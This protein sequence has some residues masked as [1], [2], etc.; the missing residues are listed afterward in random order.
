MYALDVEVKLGEI[1][2][3][4]PKGGKH[5]K[6]LNNE[7]SVTKSQQIGQARARISETEQ[8]SKHPHIVAQRNG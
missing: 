1:Y 6:S 7:R 4:V 8:M 3:A 2:Q 5:K